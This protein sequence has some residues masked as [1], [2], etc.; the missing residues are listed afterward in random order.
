M[1]TAAYADI[2]KV[3][4]SLMHK[5]FDH[6]YSYAYLVFLSRPG[7]TGWLLW[8]FFLMMSFSA[9]KCVRR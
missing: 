1:K 2:N 5:T 4:D 8:I 9:L 3:N 7:A 6:Q